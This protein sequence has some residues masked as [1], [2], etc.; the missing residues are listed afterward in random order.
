[1]MDER[2]VKL[3]LEAEIGER[4]RRAWEDLVKPFFEGKQK[5]L[6]DHFC[7]CLVDDKE[8]AASILHRRVSAHCAPFAGEP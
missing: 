4:H 5:E 8:R 1:M 6:F 2:L 7:D 3:E